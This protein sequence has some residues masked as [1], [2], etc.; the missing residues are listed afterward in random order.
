MRDEI[1]ARSC[2]PSVVSDRRSSAD[3]L[4]L[5]L[6]QGERVINNS[7]NNTKIKLKD[8]GNRSNCISG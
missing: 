1:S 4:L 6:T 3:P 2:V 5:P 7:I 8:Y